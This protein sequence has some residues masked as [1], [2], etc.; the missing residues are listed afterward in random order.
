MILKAVFLGI[1]QGLTEFL[2]VSSTGHLI[3]FG[4]WLGVSQETFGLSFDV[5]L[6]L[7]TLLAL[8]VYFKNELLQLTRAT[9]KLFVAKI[10]VATIPAVILGL[11][12]EPWIE[13]NF[14]QPTIIGWA[15]ILFGLV[16]WWADKRSF[17]KDGDA[18]GMKELSLKQ[19]LLIG[20]FQALALIPGVSRSGAT[21]SGGVFLGLKREPAAR[22]AFLLSI[23]IVFGASLKRF[24]DFGLTVSRLS[25]VDL[26]FFLVGMITAA[27]FSFLTIKFFL[28]WLKTASL[29][30]FVVYRIVLGVILLAGF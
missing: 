23:P 4:R 19:A 29:L 7:G 11:I 2:P 24:F 1:I 15:L 28:H 12:F 27:L 13:N 30:P 20:F 14:R 25:T 9:E 5:A 10:I 22:F 16:I 18:R 17:K 21:I 8:I 3:V 6:H 26:Q